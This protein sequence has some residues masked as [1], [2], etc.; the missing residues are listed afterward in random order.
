[1]NLQVNLLHPEEQRSAGL[2]RLR[3]VLRVVGLFLAT[4]MVLAA[5]WLGVRLQRLRLAVETAGEHWTRLSP[6][7]TLSQR[8]HAEF[9]QAQGIRAEWESNTRAQ[10]KLADQLESLPYLVPSGIQLAELRVSQQVIV[11]ETNVPVRLYELRLSGRTTGAMAQTH[12]RQL[13]DNLHH[14]PVLRG[15]LDQIS[16]SAFRQDPARGAGREDRVFEI[17]CKY[18]LRRFE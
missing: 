1:M 8:L 7:Y 6:E 9:A 3:R 5:L 15:T 17:L 4:V 10:L 2:V 18:K 16:S 14:E 12:V 13:L 11:V